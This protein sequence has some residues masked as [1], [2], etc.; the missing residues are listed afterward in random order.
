MSHFLLDVGISPK[1]INLLVELGHKA[2]HTASVGLE[3]A[4][5]SEILDYAIRN[6]LIVITSDL[7]FGNLAVL[8]KRP[9]PGMIIL[10]L[11]NPNAEQMLSSIRRVL[12]SKRIEE[13]RRSVTVVLPFQIRW[14]RLPVV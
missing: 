1:I 7:G 2:N 5:D 13:I 11:N 3:K 9:I 14:T 12:T 6:D 10:R 4:S 8:E